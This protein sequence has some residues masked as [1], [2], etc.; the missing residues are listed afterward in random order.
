MDKRDPFA[1]LD[2]APGTEWSVIKAAYVMLV[3][4]VEGIRG[5]ET[6]EQ[7]DAL[8]EIEWAYRE[9]KDPE[10]RLMHYRRHCK[11]IDGRL[12]ADGRDPDHSGC[13]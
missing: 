8:A 5:T 2:I 9:L 3:S 11:G 1:I 13:F 12:Y 4:R 6:E 10:R 7:L